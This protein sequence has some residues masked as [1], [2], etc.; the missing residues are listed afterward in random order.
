[1]YP[2]S[3]LCRSQEEFH[4]SRAASET[5]TNVRALAES[6]AT[7]WGHEAVAAERREA[8]GVRTRA[9]AEVI[10][11]RKLEAVIAAGET[12]RSLSEHPDRGFEA[13]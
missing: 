2:S 11:A 9:A 3:T 1:M 10:A 8:R 13:A 12:E 4:R 7:A 5:L 6:A